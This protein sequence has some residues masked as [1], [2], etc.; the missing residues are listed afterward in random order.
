VFEFGE[1][2]KAFEVMQNP[3]EVGKFVVKMS[4]E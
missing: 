2:V 4:E 1:V 3:T